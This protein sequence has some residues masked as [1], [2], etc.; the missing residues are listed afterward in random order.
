MGR[1]NSQNTNHRKSKPVKT[2]KNSKNNC[3][4]ISR[5]KLEILSPYEEDKNENQQANL[6]NLV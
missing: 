6:Y 2:S 5:P 1:Q 3:F 4:K